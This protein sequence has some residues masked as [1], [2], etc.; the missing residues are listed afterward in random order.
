MRDKRQAEGVTPLRSVPLRSATELTRALAKLY[1]DVRRGRV[2]LGTAGKLAYIGS[3]MLRAFEL[4]AVEDRV[5]RLE[6]V[7]FR[8]EN[9]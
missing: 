8:K 3:V 9:S 5:A 6:A 4:G 1:N 2:D 7:A